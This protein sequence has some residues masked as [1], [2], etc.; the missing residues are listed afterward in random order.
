MT[1]F[2]YI[3]WDVSPVAFSL[4]SVDVRWYGLCFVVAFASA[5]TVFYFI[6][7]RENRSLFLLPVTLNAVFLATLLG[8]RLGECIF[9]FPEY[10]FAHPAEIFI[11][12]KDGKYI[13]IGGLS[14]H[15]AAIA[16]P[17]ALW[18]AA[19]S[20][21]A[22]TLWLIDCVCVTVPLAA[23]FIRIGNLTNS[24]ILGTP[25]TLPWGFVFEHY[26]ENFARHPVQLYEALVYLLLFFLLYRFKNR[27]YDKMPQGVIFGLFLVLTFFARFFIEIFKAP[28]NSF[29]RQSIFLTGQ[30]LSLF[31]AVAGAVIVIT[32]IMRHKHVDDEKKIQVLS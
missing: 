6:L 1:G 9:Y 16:I 15:G 21:K 30:Y 2:N 3:H 19:R 28:I 32:L 24:E 4:G 7:K 18:F 31:F 14:S 5:S 29:D 10:Y 23:F 12:F 11:P 8:A 22:P 20:M 17:F 25:T 13:G 27:I 26:G